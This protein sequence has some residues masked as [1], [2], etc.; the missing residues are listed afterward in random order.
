MI[1]LTRFHYEAILNH[2]KREYP[3]EGCGLLAGRDRCVSSVYEMQNT[4]RSP[5]SYWMGP[6][7]LFVRFKEMRE[8]KLELVG[9][10]HS[11]PHSEA[12]PSATDQALAFYPDSFYLIVSLKDRG[13]PV[14]RVFWMK[15]EKVREDELQ[16]E[17]EPLF[18]I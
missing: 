6:K 18:I 16:I 12:F 2:L 7:E 17:R 14:S 11:H 1:T 13:R 10:Y 8:G 15:N 5:V 9:I 3:N 4:D